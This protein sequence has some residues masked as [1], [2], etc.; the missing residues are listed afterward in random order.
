[1]RIVTSN[2]GAETSGF[3]HASSRYESSSVIRPSKYDRAQKLLEWN[4]ERKRELEVGC[5]IG[6]I[7]RLLVERKCEVTGVEVDLA[8]AE[9][10]RA[11][12]R[13]VLV[14]D[15]NSL[16]WVES[17][18]GRTLDVVVLADVLEHLVDPWRVFREIAGLLDKGGAV[19][20][21]MPNVVHFLIL[22]K[23][24]L[25]H[26]NYTPTGIL[27]HSHLRFF[28]IETAREVIESY[29]YRIKRFHPAIGGGRV[30]DRIRS[31]LQFAARFAPGLFAYQVFLSA[32]C[33]LIKTC[34][35]NWPHFVIQ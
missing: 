29:E 7:S 26:F 25:G 1:M 35:S 23:I 34:E 9:K 18:G 5:S 27:D 2:R 21:S 13:E 31:G 28:T 20:I 17:F 16:Q 33:A 30:S 22:A 14:L 12:C 11:H 32:G 6:Y 19:V 15:L 4:G 3:S 24:A 10:A 8:A